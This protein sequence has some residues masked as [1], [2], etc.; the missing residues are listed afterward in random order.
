[1]TENK[2]ELYKGLAQEAQ[3]QK[4]YFEEDIK[5]TQARL[6]YFKEYQQINKI[7]EFYN[8]IKKDHQ[9]ISVDTGFIIDSSYIHQWLDEISKL[10]IIEENEDISTEIKNF[11]TQ[12]RSVL[13][14]TL[15]SEKFEKINL[16]FLDLLESI[17]RE[18]F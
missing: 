11:E 13:K 10:S 18:Y 6:T 1:M 17:G 15:E 9:T 5:R 14:N 4:E 2:K 16:D 8:K 7:K 3:E 12:N